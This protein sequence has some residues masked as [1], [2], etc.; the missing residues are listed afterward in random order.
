VAQVLQRLDIPTE[1]A[2]LILVNGRHEPDRQRGLGDGAV[3][4]VWPPIAGG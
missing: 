4:S 2:F 3:L 1:Q